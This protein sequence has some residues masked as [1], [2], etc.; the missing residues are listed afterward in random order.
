[1]RKYL[2]E[3]NSVSQRQAR[4]IL[5]GTKPEERFNLL[6]SAREKH[7]LPI[8][9][10]DRFEINDAGMWCNLPTSNTVSPEV[11]ASQAQESVNTTSS[12]SSRRS[13]RRKF[14]GTIMK[15]R[16]CSQDHVQTIWHSSSCEERA[17]LVRLYPKKMAAENVRY[18]SKQESVHRM[19]DLV[20]SLETVTQDAGTSTREAPIPL[21]GIIT[22]QTTAQLTRQVSQPLESPMPKKRGIGRL[23]EAI[24]NQT[25]CS[26]RMGEKIWLS[27]SKEQRLELLQSVDQQF[28]TPEYMKFIMGHSKSMET[29]AA[30]SANQGDASKTPPE[31]ITPEAERSEPTSAEKRTYRTTVAEPKDN[32]GW[33]RFSQD[34]D[35]TP[36]AETPPSGPP[37]SVHRLGRPFRKLTSAYKQTENPIISQKGPWKTLSYAARGQTGT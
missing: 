1:M 3:Q 25:Q 23:F 2:A 14:F 27:C 5:K 24:A 17:D 30:T 16:K 8:V 10:R 33:K 35:P 12:S 7:A 36:S 31:D 29:K 9:D 22:S 26:N 34:P 32:R 15:Q 6:Q 20:H 4:W 37:I 28:S 21:Q 13:L 18:L 11:T 19:L